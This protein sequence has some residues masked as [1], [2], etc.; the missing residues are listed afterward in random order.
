M[1]AFV[2]FGPTA[3]CA[4]MFALLLGGGIPTASAIEV[5]QQQS[6]LPEQRRGRCER[7][8][9]D[10][11]RRLAFRQG[12][13]KAN[14]PWSKAKG[15]KKTAKVE[16]AIYYEVLCPYCRRLINTSVAQLWNDTQ[17]RKRIDLKFYPYGNARSLE[18]SSVSD[19]YRFWHSELNQSGFEHVFACQH[20]QEECFGNTIQACAIDVSKEPE[21]YVP[22]L[23][24]MESFNEEYSLEMASYDC[25]EA[26]GVNANAIRD[27]TMGS[28]GNKA[29]FALGQATQNLKS[30]AGPHEY[31]PWVTLNG[32]HSEDA[33]R[34]GEDAAGGNLLMEVCK[35]LTDPKPTLC[36]QGGQTALT[37]QAGAVRRAGHALTAEYTIVALFASLRA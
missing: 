32:V 2:V 4:A 25:A 28:K 12:S 18:K 17:F 1:T 27:C 11:P 6:S 5:W 35:R 22:F 3:V 7:L 30:P 14:W 16:I 19:G 21:I 29:S 26:T 37:E 36:E 20:G 23:L 34:D 33:D 13:G 10:M 8:A 15:I 24:C 31:V 9:E